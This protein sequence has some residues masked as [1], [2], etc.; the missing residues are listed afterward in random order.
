MKILVGMSGGV[1]SSVAA[2]ILKNSGHEVIGATMTVW[3]KS[4]S[5][6]NLTGKGCF[7]FNQSDIDHAKSVCEQLNIPHHVIDCT[8]PFKEVVLQNFRNEYFSGRTPNPCVV[9][10]SKIKFNILP[11]AARRQGLVFDKFA[12]GHYA[13]II[14]NEQNKMYQIL[15]GT[16]EHKDQSYFLYRL[17]QQQLSQIILPLGNKNKTEIRELALHANLCVS[18]KNDSQDFYSGPLNDILQFTPQ[19]GNF[20]NISG[21]ILGQ[22]QGYWNFTIG[23]RRGLGISAE[24]PLYVIGINKKNNEVVV[25]FAEECQ[26]M[27]LTANNWVWHIPT[28][29]K[30]LKCQARIRSSQKL[31][32]IEATSLNNGSFE[33]SFSTPQSAITPGQSVVLYDEE[34]L[35]G[36]GIIC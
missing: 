7:S 31:F 14:F 11:D 19:T 4:G 12:T 25:G 34:K 29:E 33:I 21:K 27:K 20:I 22:H 36:G 23:Q 1:D 17:S 26:Q 6:K 13:Q 30:T 32:D 10:N 8:Q 16:D 5:F 35:L 24:R 9:C 2:L 15:R 28:P 18:H 3:D